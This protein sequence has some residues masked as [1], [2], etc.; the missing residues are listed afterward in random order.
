MNKAKIS[1]INKIS[2]K[3][4]EEVFLMF[5]LIGDFEFKTGQFVM[6]TT[7][8]DNKNIKRAYSIAT[9]NKLLQDKKQIGFYVKKASE[10]GVSNYF[11]QII[12]EGDELEITGPYGHFIDN[13]EIKNYLLISVGSGVGPI[14]GIYEEI[15]NEKN[16]F[17]KLVNIFSEKTEKNINGI[18]QKTFNSNDEKVK[19]IL[20]LS[21]DKVEGY[22]NGHI[23]DGLQEAIDFLGTKKI[24]V[25]IC[26]KPEMVDDA[27]NILLSKGIEKNNIISEKY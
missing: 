2:S 18:I 21:R 11:T 16:N 10:N 1:L 6:I 13:E 20:Y 22:R 24:K 8:I 12:K 4:N 5:K 17:N 9:T 19:N 27:T 3:T 14:L 26:G 7:N 25:F 15:I 23:Q